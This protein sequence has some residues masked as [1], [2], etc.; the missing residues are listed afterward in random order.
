MRNI[1]FIHEGAIYQTFRVDD[2]DRICS[3]CQYLHDSKIEL[4]TFMVVDWDR[5]YEI[6]LSDLYPILIEKGLITND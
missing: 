3:F 2:T 1:S 4:S 6:P 5:G